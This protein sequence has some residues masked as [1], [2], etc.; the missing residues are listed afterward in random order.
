MQTKPCARTRAPRLLAASALTAAATALPLAFAGPAVAA[1]PAPVAAPAATSVAGAPHHGARVLALPAGLRPEGVEAGPGGTLF[2]GSLA[3]GRIQ[4]LDRRT[5]SSRV[6]LP[7]V[8]GRALRGLRYDARSGL[9][10]A[11]G[12]D[13]PTAVVLAVRA[14]TGDVVRRVEVPGG[15][16]LNDLDLTRDAVWVTDSRLDRLTRIPL[17]AKGR[18][19]SAAP[20]FVTLGGDWPTPAG[21]RANGIR[22]LDRRT[23]LVVNSTAAVLRAIDVRTGVARPVRVEGTT[24][25]GGDGLVLAGR[26]LFVVRGTGQ[27]VVTQLRLVSSRHHGRATWAARFVRTLTDPALDV[28]STA[29]L[30]GGRLWAVNARFGVA[31]PATAA[32]QVVGLPLHR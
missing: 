14:R 8:E 6:L 19:T 21:N 4:V 5:G 27:T 20:S 31:D 12:N 32:Y 28:P 15:V 18:P 7:G 17:G 16:F 3:D 1:A 29:T 13:G 9:L 23:A 10:W 26:T 25:T 24:L 30:A 2:A 22:M 11:V